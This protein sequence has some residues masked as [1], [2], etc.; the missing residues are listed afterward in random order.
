ME[1]TSSQKRKRELSLSLAKVTKTACAERTL[2]SLDA[3]KVPGGVSF[4]LLSVGGDEASFGNAFSLFS[5]DA[6]VV[7]Q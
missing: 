1:L 6:F 3:A 5:N 4:F 2:T 7:L